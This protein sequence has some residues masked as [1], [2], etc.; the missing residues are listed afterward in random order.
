MAQQMATPSETNVSG[1]P[2]HLTDDPP[3]DD[4]LAAMSQGFWDAAFL[5]MDR[6][7]TLDGTDF[8]FE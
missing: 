6:V 1:L 8:Q 2:Y 3:G 5:E 7:F 4:P